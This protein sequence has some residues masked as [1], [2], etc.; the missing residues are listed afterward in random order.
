MGLALALL[1]VVNAF[2]RSPSSE[3][4]AARYF[5]TLEIERGLQ[6]SQERKLLFWLATGL[7]FALLASLVCSPWARHLADWF[8]RITGGRW[9]LTL[10][11][12]ATALFFLIE[13]ISLPVSFA[14]LEVSR[15]WNMTDR[16]VESW[17]IDRAKGLALGAVEWY[18]MIGG[19]Y[20]LMAWFPKRWWLL[21]GAAA[22]VLG[23]VY[24]LVMPEW[25]QP[26][27]NRFTPLEDI[28]LRKRIE[29][30]A[31]KA[32][33]EISDV[34]VMDA[35]RQ[36]RH[37]NAY[38][39][40]FGPTRRVVLYDTLLQTHTGWRPETI[41][42]MSG[43]AVLGGPLCAASLAAER[44]SA[45]YD[46][47]E[48]IL[49]HEIGHW[50]HDH[51]YKGLALGGLAVLAGMF[52]MSRLLSAAVGRAPFYLKSPADP[53]GLPLIVLLSTVGGWVAMPVQNAV[54]RGFERQADMAALE[55]AGKPDAFIEAEKRMARDN[56]ANV[57]PTP[58]NTWLFSTHPPPV[59]RIEMAEKWK[60]RE[61]Q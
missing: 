58:F 61:K 37:T 42:A 10:F 54:S 33:V 31:Q 30:L 6:F 47:L 27:F 1:F 55:L 53:A 24:A 14:S 11:L 29:I 50:Q 39:V 25:I 16:S 49:G 59:D 28:Y 46:E 52:L 48:T 43:S 17:L 19:L 36:G 44:Q 5:S 34:E 2:I 35:S 21:A 57:A 40:G 38:F 20:A 45:G 12:V 4:L 56:I 41:A 60:Q 26:I 18:L 51:I 7:Q 15:A 13:A 32:G 8:A 23:V 9:F 3:H 22:M